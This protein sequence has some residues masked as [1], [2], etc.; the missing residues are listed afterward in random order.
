MGVCFHILTHSVLCSHNTVARLGFHHPLLKYRKENKRERGGGGRE[1]Q[2]EESSTP[3]AWHFMVKSLST[4]SSH[5]LPASC[6]HRVSVPTDL[7]VL[8][9]LTQLLHS[10]RLSDVSE[11]LPSLLCPSTAVCWP[12]Q[13][14][15]CPLL[16]PAHFLSTRTPGMG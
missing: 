4:S 9:T 11:H 1:K 15:P 13:T 6:R 10:S 12:L 2:T 14:M 16:R 3:L 5:P 7:L 8:P